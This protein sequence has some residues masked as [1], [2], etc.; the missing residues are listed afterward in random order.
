MYRTR[1]WTCFEFESATSSAAFKGK[2]CPALSI[3]HHAVGIRCPCPPET[4]VINKGKCPSTHIRVLDE[5]K[6]YNR[7]AFELAHNTLFQRAVRS[8]LFFHQFPSHLCSSAFLITEIALKR[9][10]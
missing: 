8:S 3:Y 10:K 5:T 9:L 7:A 6:L 1:A 4:S 2:Y